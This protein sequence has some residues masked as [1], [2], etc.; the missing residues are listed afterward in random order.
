MHNNI[1]RVPLEE[2]PM[3][4]STVGLIVILVFSVLIA[5]LTV[6]AQPP[7]KMPRIGIFWLESQATAAAHFATLQQDL[8]DLGYVEGQNIAFEQRYG[9]WKGGGERLHDLA[10]ELVQLNVDV[11]LALGTPVARAAQRATTRIPIVFWA[12]ADPVEAGLVASLAH[13]G[14]NLTGLTILAPEQS[15]KRLEL[16]TEAVPGVSRVAVLWNPAD[17]YAAL[18]V[19]VMEAAA[20]DLG[21]QLQ[22]LEVRAPSEFERAFAAATRDG[23]GALSILATP[24]IVQHLDRI[25]HLALTHRLPAMFW[26]QRFAEAGGL[27]AYG[28][29]TRDVY[30]RAAALVSKILRGAKPADL[31]VEQP[32]KFELVINLKTAQALGITIPPTLLFL[33]D[34]V[35]Q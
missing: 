33:A 3:R 23:A 7:T 5:P 12:V 16:L 32:M 28:P 13:P 34:E 14:G 4:R 30:R 18:E 9:D 8:S 29:S 11:I 20:R 21:V 2:E 25:V 31:P 1:G 35:I 26:M 10:A 15:G 22:S 27:M 6:A 19:H 24:F 17:R